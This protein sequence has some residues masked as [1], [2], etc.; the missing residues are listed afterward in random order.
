MIK[1][2]VDLC[3]ETE[4][5]SVLYSASMGITTMTPTAEGPLR[6]EGGGARDPD[7]AGADL[8]RAQPRERH[9]AR[10]GDDAPAW[11][12]E[13][14][15]IMGMTH[16]DLKLERRPPSAASAWTRRLEYFQ[17]LELFEERFSPVLADYVVVNDD[18]GNLVF[19]ALMRW[20][21]G[22]RW[23][24]ASAY[25]EGLRAEGGE[26]SAWTDGRCVGPY[27]LKRAP[28]CQVQCP[29]RCLFPAAERPAA[30]IRISHLLLC[31]IG[32]WD[33]G[34]GVWFAPLAWPLDADNTTPGRPRPRGIPG[35]SLRSA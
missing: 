30:G 8:R 19:Q 22:V 18:L 16:A 24:G 14:W 29:W 25:T 1:V 2:L 31:L 20:E 12:T 17:R 33:W 11:L 4:Q 35:L 5:L 15:E 9:P 26:T 28:R 32:D 21:G 34:L 10:E 7:R 27:R 23:E 3:P 6:C 13:A